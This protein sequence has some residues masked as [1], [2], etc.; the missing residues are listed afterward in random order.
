MFCV[1]GGGGVIGGGLT[2]WGGLRGRDR[3]WEGD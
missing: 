3:D 2:F 1:G